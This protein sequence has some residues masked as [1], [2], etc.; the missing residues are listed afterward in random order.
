LTVVF[1]VPI[2]VAKVG[3]CQIKLKR[4][5]TLAIVTPGTPG[6]VVGTRILQLENLFKTMNT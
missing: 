5:H 6:V 1:A 4:K 3:Y 2:A